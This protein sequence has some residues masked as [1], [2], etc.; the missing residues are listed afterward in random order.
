MTVARRGYRLLTMAP[1]VLALGALFVIPPTSAVRKGDDF[2]TPETTG[3]LN[4]EPGECFTDP[5]YS[6][7]AGEE[8]VLY[9]TCDQHADNQSYGF[10]H[11][12]DGPYDRAALAEFGWSSCKRGF[13]NYWPGEAGAELD[14]YP[15][16]PTA[17]TWAD[18]DRDVMCVVYDPH[19]EL[20][21]SMLPRA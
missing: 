2:M 5:E 3:V 12:D 7:M 17:E 20:K 1:A 9:T 19:G 6:P 18:G 8:I 4:L 21:G 14:Y 11:A 15:I 10:V 13:A 16:L